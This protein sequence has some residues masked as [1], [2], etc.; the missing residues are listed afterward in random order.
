MTMPED[1][2]DLSALM[3]SAAR[4]LLKEI[5]QPETL[6]PIADKVRVF[7]AASDWLV[8]RIKVAPPPKV[9]SKFSVLQRK[10]H[11]EPKRRKVGGGG[12]APAPDED[13]V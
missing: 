12:I 4:S 3:D 5:A 2:E 10:L 9:E 6:I 13:E 7:G 1:D 8:A 11:A